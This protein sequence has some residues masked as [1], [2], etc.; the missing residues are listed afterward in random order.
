MI[1]CIMVI[2]GGMARFNKQKGGDKQTGARSSK[3]GR[4]GGANANAMG[5]AKS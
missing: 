4:A 3:Y 5:G 2:V 1:L